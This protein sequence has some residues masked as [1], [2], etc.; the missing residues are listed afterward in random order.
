MRKSEKDLLNEFMAAAVQDQPKARRMLKRRPELLRADYS[1]GETVLHFLAIENYTE[2]VRFLAQAGA[3][4]NTKNK[5]GD[6]PLIS[7]AQL[8]H[9]EM[10]RILLQFGAKFE[11]AVHYDGQRPPLCRPFRQVRIV[12]ALLQAG[13]DPHYHTDL[14]ETVFSNL[15]RP[16]IKREAILAVLKKHG[17]RKGES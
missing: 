2:A 17:I 6:T 9:E 5:F 7:A 13:A 14:D 10:V 3:D 1:L 12:D 8:G 11:R 15:P 4:V 16:G